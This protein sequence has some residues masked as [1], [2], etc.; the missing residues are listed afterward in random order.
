MKY[1]LLFLIL[2]N[3]CL[4]A[5]DGI[6]FSFDRPMQ[7][8]GYLESLFCNVEG[9]GKVAVICRSSN[10]KFKKAYEK[11]KSSFPQVLFYEQSSRKEF[12]PLF[13]KLFEETG[14]YLFFATDDLFVRSKINLNICQE[15][16]GTTGSYGFYFRL[17]KNINRSYMIGN[18][19]PAPQ[20]EAIS[21][22][23]F[24]FKFFGN[25]EW[26]YPNSVDMVLFEKSS[27]DK[28]LPFLEFDKP[29]SLEG[30]WAARANLNAHGLCFEESK[31]VNIPANKVNK[32]TNKFM[33]SY[34]VVKLL[35]L[36]NK[37]FLLDVAE[38]SK[39][40]PD[41]PHMPIPLKFKINS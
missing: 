31:V 24:K 36:F 35:E 33:N 25:S 19:A 26:A 13:I 2:I 21:E 30:S 34:S 7:L 37:G 28:V 6:V 20:M 39:I 16:L 17:G 41:S 23:I 4:P 18:P 5:A 32:S 38:M 22:G 10:S 1:K 27:L 29:N 8:H 14:Q 12:K 15:L 9:L 40:L 11:V 3:A